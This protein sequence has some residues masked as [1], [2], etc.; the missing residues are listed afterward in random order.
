MVLWF[1]ICTYVLWF[2]MQVLVISSI[3]RAGARRF[4][5]FLAYSV[6]S[7]LVAFAQ[8]PASVARFQHRTM[9][10]WYTLVHSVGQGIT[11]A[12]ALAVVLNLIHRASES[13]T[14]RNILRL[15][16][17]LGS[18]AM[19][20]VSL[21]F[22]YDSRLT[23]EK[24]VIPWTRDL[25]FMA[26]ILDLVLWSLLLASRKKDNRLLMLT[27]GLG[28]MFAGETIGSALQTMA[29]RY[30]STLL[31]YTSVP[32]VLGV[33]LAFMYIWWQAFRKESAQAKTA[34]VRS[35]RD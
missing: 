6:V 17:N 24:W 23:I 8:I 26:A 21:F 5:L 9:A 3:W 25:N 16:V 1:Q 32:F 33:D 34:G 19:V 31:V 35:L 30:R 29:I 22:H 10:P 20:G 13:A 14:G 18:L 28:I 15:V 27:A 11:Y 4:I 12:L 2:P 7:L